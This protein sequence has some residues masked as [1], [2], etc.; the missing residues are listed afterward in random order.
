M[1]LKIISIIALISIS[2]LVNAQPQTPTE[3]NEAA[4]K[5][6]LCAISFFSPDTIAIC[7]PFDS[8]DMKEIEKNISRAIGYRTAS[9]IVVISDIGPYCMSGIACFCRESQF[10][11]V[12]PQ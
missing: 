1:R 6:I 3:R 9:D 4:S 12:D 5:T 2:L 7:G 8:A 11:S 10:R